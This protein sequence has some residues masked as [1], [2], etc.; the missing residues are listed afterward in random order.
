MAIKVLPSVKFKDCLFIVLV[1]II[2]C[3]LCRKKWTKQHLPSKVPLGQRPW[4]QCSDLTLGEPKTAGPNSPFLY[5]V[6]QFHS[7]CLF[8]VVYSSFVYM[9]VCFLPKSPRHQCRVVFLPATD[10]HSTDLTEKQLTP[11]GSGDQ[12]RSTARLGPSGQQNL[13]SPDFRSPR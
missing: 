4:R 9:V 8:D 7:V 12:R 5:V 3:Q 6:M 2:D 11:T 10:P 13:P 1:K